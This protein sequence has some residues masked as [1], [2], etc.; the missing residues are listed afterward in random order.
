GGFQRFVVQPLADRRGWQEPDHA[1]GSAPV[2]CAAVV[3]TVPR[4]MIHPAPD[5]QVAA[6][7]EEIRRLRKVENWVGRAF[8]LALIG[9]VIILGVLFKF[10][11]GL[12]LW[13]W[14]PCLGLVSVG[15]TPLVVLGRSPSRR[16]IA[17]RMRTL[18]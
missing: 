15:S 16:R 14:L 5:D 3:E 8:M 1:G 9:P 4:T 10:G 2:R 12:M 13:L 11:G 18:S 6:L 7:R 17:Q